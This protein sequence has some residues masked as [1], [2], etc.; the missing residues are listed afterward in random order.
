MKRQLLVGAMAAA[1][2]TGFAA[3]ALAQGVLE[4]VIVTAQKR[5]E[6]AQ[7]IG[8]SIA[9]LGGDELEQLGIFSAADL[10]EYVPNMELALSGDSDIPI[11]VIRGV[12]LQDF[13]PNNTPTTAIFVDDV[14]LPYGVYGSFALFDSER[15]EVLRGPQGGLYGRNSTGGAINVISRK[16]SFETVEA[17]ISGDVGNYGTGN[18][19]G[20][21][22]VPLGDLFAA[23]LATQV[24]RS[25]GYYRNTYLGKDQGGKDKNEARLTLSFEPTDTFAADLRLT[26]GT[27]KSEV[28]IPELEGYLDPNANLAQAVDLLG[29]GFPDMNVPW[30]PILDEDGNQVGE[31]PAFC[32]AVLRTGIP[33]KSCVTMNR[34]TPDGKYRGGDAKIRHKDDEYQAAALNLDWDLGPVTLVSITSYTD[35]QFVATNGSGSVGVGPQQ[36]GEAWEALGAALGRINGGSV[37]DAYITVYDNNIDSWSQELRLLSN[38]DGAVSWMLGAVYAEDDLQED[39]YCE[40]TSN[41]YFDWAVFPGCGTMPYEQNTE[42]MSAYGQVS[43]QFT[44]TLRLTADARITKE[45]KDYAGDVYINDGSYICLANGLEDPQLCAAETGFDPET[46]LFP[47]AVGAKA[48]YDETE[49]SWKVNL[50]WTPVDD[51]LVYGSVAHTFKSGG[52]YGGFF[53]D[54][55]EITAYDPETN[56]SVELGFKSTL[57]NGAMQFN[58]AVF[59]YDYKDWQGN[60]QSQSLSGADGGAVFTALTNLGDVET[61]GAELDLRWLPLEG[62][63]LRLGLGWLDTE[64]TDVARTSDNPDVITG[65]TNIFSQVVDIKGN[66]INNAPNFSANLFARYDFNLSSSLGAAVQGTVA[67]TDDYYLSVSNEPY[68]KEDGVALVNARAE[69]YSLNSGWTVAIWGRNLTDESYRT[70]TND[71]GIYSNYSNWSAPRTFGATLSYRF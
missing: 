7:D 20:G 60:L 52:F 34:A 6:S 48:D 12:G 62:L 71:D 42:A 24:E 55:D 28:S 27:D 23:R 21:I 11:V 65:V 17:D 68:S 70:S 64:V 46:G 69:L 25:D 39:R 53:F 30:N 54:A 59:R 40:F 66:E 33:D 22:S 31:A 57:L 56:T 5:A 45:Q 16:P 41:L 14:Y 15:V 58:G 18:L 38:S 9:A 44:D 50:D 1:L 10:S 37:A 32:D 19:R 8:I 13:N 35:L 47:L 26:Y 4:E 43:W 36:N 67:W 51:L 2:G 49:P 61:L 63:D 3:T 29:A